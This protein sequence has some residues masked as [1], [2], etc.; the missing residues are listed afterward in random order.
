MT[1]KGLLRNIRLV[2][3]RRVEG[4]T[5]VRQ[6]IAMVRIC[7]GRN[8]KA[9]SG[10]R[11]RLL[12]QTLRRFSEGL[13]TRDRD[14]HA[15]PT[16]VFPSLLAEPRHDGADVVDPAGRPDGPHVEDPAGAGQ[17]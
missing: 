8:R 12:H 17:A 5:P 14:G 9:G 7:G 10:C 3:I 16:A 15:F 13:R 6:V 2:G 11:A 4:R 1:R